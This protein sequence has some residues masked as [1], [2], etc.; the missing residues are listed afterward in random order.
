MLS[1]IFSLL[2]FN[3]VGRHFDIFFENRPSDKNDES[4][5]NN[6]S[7]ELSNAVVFSGKNS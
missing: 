6:K 7:R 2:A 3:F 1:N 5:S 4:A